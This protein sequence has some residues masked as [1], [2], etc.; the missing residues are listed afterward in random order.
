M[1]LCVYVYMCVFVYVHVCVC[2]Y[3]C[4]CICICMC[5]SVCIQKHKY[6]HT[7]I[8]CVCMFLCVECH[9]TIVALLGLLCPCLHSPV[10]MTCSS[11]LSSGSL[12]SVKPPASSGGPFGFWY[13]ALSSCPQFTDDSKGEYL[14]GARHNL[15]LLLQIWNPRL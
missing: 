12:P 15:S 2:V 11:C 4:L 10:A 6:I 8:Q 9:S 5:M 3:V 7:L 14:L 1:Y 13:K